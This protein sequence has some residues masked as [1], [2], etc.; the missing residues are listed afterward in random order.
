M[1]RRNDAAEDIRGV[2]GH[3]A[4]VVV[5]GEAHVGGR[6]PLPRAP[7]HHRLEGEPVGLDEEPRPVALQ[8]EEESVAEV[9]PVPRAGL[10][11][12]P[13]ALLLQELVHDG[14]LVDL[15]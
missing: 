10:D 13:V 1:V 2:K 15:P 7:E 11:E 14:R 9:L 12:E 6:G 8:L 4:R 5:D 3:L